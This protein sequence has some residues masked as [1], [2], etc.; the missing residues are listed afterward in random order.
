MMGRTLSGVGTVAVLLT[1]LLPSASVHAQAARSGGGA[2][3]LLLQQMQQLASERTSL[4]A[5]NKKMEQGLDEL[6]KERDALKKSQQ[7]VA[8]R[9][10]ASTAALDRANNQHAEAV[11]QLAQTK[12]EMQDL[13]AKFRETI[14]KLK[15][16]E[17]ESTSAK[18]AVAVSERQLNICVDHDMALYK[19]DL[20]VLSHSGQDSRWAR[21]ARM[22]PFTQ[23]G[24]ARLENRVDDYR[25]RANDLRLDP[26]NRAAWLPPAGMRAPPP[27]APPAQAASAPETRGGTP[28]QR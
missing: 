21:V 3:A 25:G 17:A 1:V 8:Q 7:A 12:A 20:E 28:S 19:L 10:R 22:E 15:E 24:R 13:I 16:V 9:T 18:Q 23:I 5:E 4:Q 27:P 2:N 14:Q 26:E 6:R 11:R